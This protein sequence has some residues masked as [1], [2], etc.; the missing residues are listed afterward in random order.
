MANGSAFDPGAIVGTRACGPSDTTCAAE[1]QSDIEDRLASDLG[2]AGNTTERW[3][4]A[5]FAHEGVLLFGLG[6]REGGAR[7]ATPPSR[8][9]PVG[10]NGR[11]NLG[12]RRVNV[13]SS[14][15]TR[16]E[17]CRWRDSWPG[18]LSRADVVHAFV[19]PDDQLANAIRD[20]VL[21]K[22]LWL[23]PDKFDVGVANGNVR[24]GGRVERSGPAT[25]TNGGRDRRGGP[26]FR[27]AR[28][29]SSPWLATS[30]RTRKR[31]GRVTPPQARHPATMRWG[32][33]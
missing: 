32:R 20:D 24:I 7:H 26:V 17:T 22:T 30:R 25:P 33:P 5:E 12:E 14:A 10:T 28:D 2:L 11:R 8:P 19:R 29:R 21:Y 1:W 6:I 18:V 15:A 16:L 4:G 27:P 13:H 31:A 9:Y 23:D 3:V